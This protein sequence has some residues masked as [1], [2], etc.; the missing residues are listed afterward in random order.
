MSMDEHPDEREEWSGDLATEAELVPY[1]P[2]PPPTTLFGTTDPKKPLPPF[3]ASQTVDGYKVQLMGKPK[4]RAIEAALMKVKVTD[5]SGK[6]AKFVPYFGALAHAIFFRQGNLD[7]FHTH[8]CAPGAAGCTSLLGG[9]SVTGRSST[10]G[11]LTVGVLLPEPGRW[12]LFLQFESGGKLITAP[13][14]LNVA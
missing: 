13:F 4:L 12:R 5:P 2:P 11:N 1:T 6:P 8:V 3:Q 9:A 7:Y 14:T 10:P